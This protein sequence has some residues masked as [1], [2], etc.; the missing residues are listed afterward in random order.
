MAGAAEEFDLLPGFDSEVFGVTMRGWGEAR[1][2]D[3]RLIRGSTAAD[4]AGF[5]EIG[6]AQDGRVA[7]VLVVGQVPDTEALR[8]LV[9]DR[10]DVSGR[11]EGL[12][13]PAVVVG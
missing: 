12:R 13:D 8:K 3:R 2:V 7:Q 11:E 4:S 5:A 6:I 10:T 9:V 1:L